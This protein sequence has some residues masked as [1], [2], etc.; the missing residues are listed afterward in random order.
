MTINAF[1][2]ILSVRPYL[3][4]YIYALNKFW[5]TQQSEALIHL[6]MWL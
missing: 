3:I 5:S 1:L 6:H 2:L 4:I